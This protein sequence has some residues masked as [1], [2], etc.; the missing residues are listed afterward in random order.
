MESQTLTEPDQMDRGTASGRWQLG[1]ACVLLL[2]C[3][4]SALVVLR[5]TADF[6]YT[7]SLKFAALAYVSIIPIG[8]LLVRLLIPDV[9]AASARWALIV[10][11]GY[12]ASVLV[13]FFCGVLGIASA[14]LP[15]CLVC[16]AIM[17]VWWSYQARRDARTVGRDASLFALVPWWPSRDACVVGALVAVGILAT[18]PL[19][20]PVQ[21]ISP[22][23]YYDY[24][25]IDVYFFTA[26]AQVLMHGAPAYTLV[27]L[28]GATPYVYPDLHLFWMGQMALWSRI[29]VNAVY[30]V[31]APIVLIGLYTLTMYALGKEM[32]GSRWGG[33]I[34]GSLP[35]VLLLSSFH[36]IDPYLATPSLAHF[37]DLR[38]ALSHGVAAMLITAIALCATLSLRSTYRR[39]TLI[40]LLTIAGVLSMFLVRLRPH[41]FLAVSPW[42]G[43]LV[44]LHVWR[45]RDLRYAA[46]LLVAGLVFA[47]LYVESTSAHY[48]AGSTHLALDYGLFGRQT[49]KYKQF[50]DL[51]QSG[52]RH[53]PAM[54]Q[55]LAVSGAVTVF[56][57]LGGAFVCILIGYAI[58]LFRRRVRLS[59]AETG[60]VLVWLTAIVLSSVVILDA[61]RNAGGDWGFQALV[62]AGPVAQILAIVP[63]YY[64]LRSL[65]SRFPALMA[66]RDILALGVLVL[67][68]TVTY[69][70]ADSVLRSQLQRAYPITTAEMNGYRWIMTNTPATSVLAADPDHAVNA[71]GET[72]ATTSFLAGQTRRPAYLQRVAE[73]F[74]EEATRRRAILAHVFDAE[75]PDAVNTALQG[76]AFDYLLVYPDKAPRTDLSCCLTGVYQDTSIA[77]ATFRIYRRERGRG[78]TGM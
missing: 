24:A 12:C 69:R 52:L 42:Y 68:T 50:P 66:N 59:I 4:A 8:W 40:G 65:G 15:L 49:L 16:L 17:L 64:A 5:S 47:A 57:L 1:G 37:L 36:D 67:A 46:P 39:R 44:L 76:A 74:G 3:C 63:L 14:Y 72:V 11:V 34:G 13:G 20:A 31:Y 54:V 26:R 18:T 73:Y 41:F 75:T 60:L 58:L 7:R 6:G 21:Q 28:A 25:F 27:D 48:T 33:Y 23:L 55:P 10:T 45:R 62:I 71:N 35:Y 19:M 43:L 30:L 9:R 51:V 61:R 38:T 22:S 2:V 70:G 32:T 56:Q 29:D 77:N 53:L 78:R